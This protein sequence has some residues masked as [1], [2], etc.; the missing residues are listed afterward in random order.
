MPKS[1]KQIVKNSIL[2]LLYFHLF[3]VSKSNAWHDIC[4][5]VKGQIEVAGFLLPPRGSQG[6][7]S[8][9]RASAFIDGA[10]LPALNKNFT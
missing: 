1:Q 7:K 9:L 2:F 4:V 6:S 8:S 10:I 3:I 5:Y